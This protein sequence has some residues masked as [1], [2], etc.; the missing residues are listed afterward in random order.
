[1]LVQA[2]KTEGQLNVIACPRTGRTA[3]VNGTT[4]PLRLTLPAAAEIIDWPITLVLGAAHALAQDEHG[5]VA[6]EL[7]APEPR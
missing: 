1:M 3:A 4:V 2:A 7:G 5:R 6:A